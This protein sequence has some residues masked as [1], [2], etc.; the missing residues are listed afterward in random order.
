MSKTFKKEEVVRNW[1]EGVILF[2]RWLQIK[3]HKTLNLI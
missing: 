1:E 3:N 2:I